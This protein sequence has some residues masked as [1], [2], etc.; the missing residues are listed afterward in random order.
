MPRRF[1]GAFY[2][3]R[4]G[5]FICMNSKKDIRNFIRT[6]REKMSKDEVKEKSSLIFSNLLTLPAFFRADVVHTYISS[7]KNETDTHELIRWLIKERKKVVVPISE[8]ETKTMR[9]SELL[10]LSDL[11]VNSMGI[12]EPK[13]ERLVKVSDLDVVLVPALAVDKT[14]NRLGFG[15]GFYDRFLNGLTI[16]S[17]ALAFD[18]QL[19]EDIPAEEFDVKMNYIVTESKILKC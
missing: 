6:K 3:Y 18:F 2:F 1:G 7:K 13:L 11:K 15:A 4:S 17:V 5:W 14:G 16:P 10:A 12:Y 19:L 8:M 9:H